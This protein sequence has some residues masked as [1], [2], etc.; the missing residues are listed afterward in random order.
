MSK[1]PFL[2]KFARGS[3]SQDTPENELGNKKPTDTQAAV[4]PQPPTTIL[5]KVQN[6]TTDDT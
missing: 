3:G 4:I 1:I 5:T 6:E 2:I